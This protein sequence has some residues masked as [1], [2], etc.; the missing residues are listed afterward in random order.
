MAGS[1]IP[2]PYTYEN[3]VEW[4]KART[5]QR[6][7]IVRAAVTLAVAAEKAVIQARWAARRLSGDE[8]ICAAQM[9]NREIHEWLA[10]LGDGGEEAPAGREG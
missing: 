6:R 3:C 8:R 7:G 9:K 5:P 2:Y 1:K 4:L 10:G